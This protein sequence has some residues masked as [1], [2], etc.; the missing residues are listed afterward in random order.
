MIRLG[1]RSK[2]LWRSVIGVVVAYA[3]AAQSLLVVLAGFSLLAH[4]GDNPPGFELCIHD[5]Q[6]ASESPAG[7]PNHTECTHCIFCLAGSHHAVIR[8]PLLSFHRAYV[9]V[10]DISWV[11]YWQTIHRPPAHSIASPR[12]PPLRG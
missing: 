5:S 3:V 1:C 12:G 6:G 4:A 2:R 11:V 9:E 10:I 8:A 7:N